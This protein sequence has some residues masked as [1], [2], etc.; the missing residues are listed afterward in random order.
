MRLQM[1]T[2]K[3]IGR[4]RSNSVAQTVDPFLEC[5]LPQ[6]FARPFILAVFFRVKHD[7][8]SERATTHSL[9]CMGSLATQACSTGAALTITTIWNGFSKKRFKVISHNIRAVM[10]KIKFSK[11]PHSMVIF[12]IRVRR[13]Y[14]D[15]SSRAD[16]VR[17]NQ[18]KRRF[19]VS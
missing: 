7:G 3:S 5:F 11:K 18:L 1:H 10:A 14:R 19:R 13:S 4:E 12:L 17:D 16:P 15:L 6:D 8:L 9:L 2:E